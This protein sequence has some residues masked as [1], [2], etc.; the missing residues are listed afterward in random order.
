M[1]TR[2]SLR[3]V[4]FIIVITALSWG[5]TLGTAGEI[6]STE[7]TT[8]DLD[9]VLGRPF[10]I[11]S[12]SID[13][14][15]PAVAYN[16]QEKEFLVVWENV[17]TV[18]N[19]IYAQRISDQGEFLSWFFV[20][21]GENPA[22]AYNPKNNTYL[23]VYQKDVGGEYDINASR[24]DR[25]GSIQQLMVAHNINQSEANP[26]VAYNTH[27]GHDEF[28]VVWDTTELTTP[29]VEAQR[30]AGTK[31]GGPGGNDFLGSRIVVANSNDDEYQPDVAY[32]LN[33]NEYLVVYS[34][35]VGV[36]WD[37]YGRRIT[38][39]G[40]PLTV[41][42]IA[43]YSNHQDSPSAAA[44]RL[45]TDTPYLVVFTDYYMDTYGDV[46]GYF[47]NQQGQP[48]APIDISYMSWTENTPAIA[49]S[50]AWNSYFVA[51]YSGFIGTNIGGK[52]LYDNGLLDPVVNISD[53][54]SISC[55]AQTPEI[56][57]G[58]TSALVVWSDDCGTAGGFDI[59]GRLLGY[60]QQLPLI[61]RR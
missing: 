6:A 42:P 54:S 23:I 58:N 4:V 5:S 32:N 53:H 57:V 52:R 41:T 18:D 28:L 61:I 13:E 30:V 2:K 24:V 31:E 50:E 55:T 17:R 12:G 51:W 45:D 16:S 44:N 14:T 37:V 26:S 1:F 29:W 48:I 10:N 15:N 39:N 33:M 27:P 49:H 36:E 22:V 21:H 7:A 38:G 9:P 19:D 60:Q 3:L 20:D 35:R 43:A 25:T 11:S 34:R 47:V 46:R 59:L 40:V 8:N 56:A